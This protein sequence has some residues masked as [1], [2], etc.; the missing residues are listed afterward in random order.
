MTDVAALVAEARDGLDNLAQWASRYAEQIPSGTVKA[1]ALANAV[2][3]VEAVD[4][5]LATAGTSR[6]VRPPR[7]ARVARLVEVMHDAPYEPV[8]ERQIEAFAGAVADADLWQFAPVMDRDALA[9][10]IR[11]QASGG[12]YQMP[13][14]ALPYEAW[15]LA[16]ADALL[17]FIGQPAREVDSEA[18][19]LAVENARQELEW[20]RPGPDDAVEV[21]ARDLRALIGQPASPGTVGRP[22]KPLREAMIDAGAFRNSPKRVVVKAVDQML[23]APDLW[24]SPRTVT[25]E[26]PIALALGS[27]RVLGLV[28]GVLSTASVELNNLGV[29][30]PE[31]EWRDLRRQCDFLT[32]L[33]DEYARMAGSSEGV[34]S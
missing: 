30:L 18:R 2:R 27:S 19:A 3:W 21:T 12:Q 7:E 15:S 9:A 6:P 26:E 34:E 31:S 1:E 20:A 33:T 25:T 11:E 22:E 4:A 23:A 8:M 17:P 5:A 16:M 29:T 32:E 10:V 13:G 28:A 14:D 24:A